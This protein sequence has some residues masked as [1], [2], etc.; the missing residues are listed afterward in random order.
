[1]LPTDNE[2]SFTDDDLI[3]IGMDAEDQIEMNGTYD[4]DGNDFYAILARLWA[5]EE[6]AK[7]VDVSHPNDE[8]CG[9]SMCDLL[10]DW[11]VKCGK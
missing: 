5:A 8:N 7:C 3:A 9:C 2:R 10:K 4:I 11:K 6:I 1:M